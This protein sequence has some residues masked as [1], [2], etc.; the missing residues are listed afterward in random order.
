MIYNFFKF[1]KLIEQKITMPVLLNIFIYRLFCFVAKNSAKMILIL[2][3]YP[4][5]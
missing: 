2:P 1:M 3:I 5:L 4:S